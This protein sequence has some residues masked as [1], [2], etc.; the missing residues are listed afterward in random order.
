MIHMSGLLTLQG[1][2]FLLMALGLFFKRRGIVGDGFQQ[3]LTELIIGLILPCNIIDSFDVKFSLTI[4]RQTLSV[5]LVSLGIQLG[6]W[7]LAGV[8]YRRQSPDKLPVLQYGTI[9]SNAGFL[10]NPVAQGIFGSRGLLLASIYL[11][12]QRVAM[13]TLGVSFFA[14]SDHRALWRKVLLH[15]CIDAVFMGLVLLV[16]Q[17]QLPPVLSKTIQA[18]GSCNTAMSMFLIGMIMSGIRWRDFSDRSALFYSAVR[19]LLIPALVLL[20]CRLCRVGELATGVSVVLAAMPAGGT[21]AILAAKYDC[22]AEFAANC[23][24]VSTLLSLVAVPLWC[25]VLSL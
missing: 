5:L 20:G 4:L 1:E 23:V 13:W 12:P 9:C 17:W 16:T 2:L 14:K 3:G 25:S 18:L 7:L 24:T 8:L 10:G 6:C 11:I 21:T 15:P 19:L 22:N